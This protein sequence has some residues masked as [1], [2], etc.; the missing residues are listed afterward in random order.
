MQTPLHCRRTKSNAIIRIARK[1]IRI[2]H[3]WSN[4]TRK[5]CKPV[6]RAAF[7]A[8]SLYK[9]IA[10]A[11]NCH[12][13][14]YRK[15]RKHAN[16]SAPSICAA[17]R[18]APTTNRKLFCWKYQVSSKPINWWWVCVCVRLSSQYFWIKC[19]QID[20]VEFEWVGRIFESAVVGTTSIV[21]YVQ[22][23]CYFAYATTDCRQQSEQQQ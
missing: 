9:V 6:K 1:W 16:I 7:A 8:A 21:S 14:T 4:G 23:I 3:T 19:F 13:Q 18:S 2:R 5:R 17:P 12:R 10:I 22:W 11:V 15:R 20:I